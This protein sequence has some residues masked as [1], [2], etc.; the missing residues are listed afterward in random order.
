MNTYL[1]TMKKFIFLS[2]FIKQIYFVSRPLINHIYKLVTVLHTLIL[3]QSFSIS[4]A[5]F[6][7]DAS[8]GVSRGRD[9]SC[10]LESLFCVV[11]KIF[12]LKFTFFE[13]GF[14][15]LSPTT[16]RYDRKE[17]FFGFVNQEQTWCPN[18]ME[19]S[20]TRRITVEKEWQFFLVVLN[21]RIGCLSVSF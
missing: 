3:F 9:F 12:A 7:K 19:T 8:F 4:N 14:G 5:L 21:F 10:K 6:P 18:R 2:N 1:L 16:C 20:N 15:F 13:I 11:T 17:I